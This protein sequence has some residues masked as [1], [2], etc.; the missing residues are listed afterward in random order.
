VVFGDV[1]DSWTLLGAAIVVGS[2]LYILHRERM[3][4]PRRRKATET[5]IET[6][7]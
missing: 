5:A 4:G 6:G 2:G 7:D 3:S 1:P